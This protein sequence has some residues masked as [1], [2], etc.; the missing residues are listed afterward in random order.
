MKSLITIVLFLCAGLVKSQTTADFENFNL[1]IDSF[2]NDANDT[3]FFVSGDISLPNEYVYDPLYPYWNGWSISTMM[4]AATPGSDNQYS[5]IAGKGASGSNTYA[6]GYVFGYLDMYLSGST[7]GKTVQGVYL[8]NSTYAYLSMLNGDGF[9]KKFGGASGND[10]D[11]FKL[12]IRKLLN[13]QIGTDS[14]E[15]YLADYRFA[16]NAQ[17]YIVKDWTYLDISSLGEADLIQFNLS[18]SDIGAF[19]MNTPSY[20]CI[21]NVTTSGLTPVEEQASQLFDLKIW[22]NPT[23]GFLLFNW[24]NEYVATAKITTTYAQ[25][26]K[27]F[28]VHSGQNRLDIS[29][30]PLGMFNLQVS[31]GRQVASQKFIKQ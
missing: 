8:N 30:L 2:D 18:S 17:D 6:V 7:S 22:P 28:K 21:D 13:G 1:P 3:G 23:A 16:N 24:A 29:D 31:N 4:D 26:V 14:I 19:G 12:T 10:P 15:F 11:F 9:A 5:C 27:Q 25:V 20:F